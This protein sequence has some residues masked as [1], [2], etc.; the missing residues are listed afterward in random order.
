LKKSFS[1]NWR[2]QLCI[3]LQ[4]KRRS[5]IPRHFASPNFGLFGA[6]REFFNSHE[7]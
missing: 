5:R 1:R 7:I 2:K 4:F 3:P 6:E